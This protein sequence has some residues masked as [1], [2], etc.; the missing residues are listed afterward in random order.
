VTLGIPRLR[1]IVMT[2]TANIATPTMTLT[3]NP[4]VSNAAAAL[5]AKRCSKLMLAEI[6]DHVSVTETIT[7][8][9]K[10]FLIRLD[11]FSA[12]EYQNE[13]SL[14]K[15]K[16]LSVLKNRFLKPLEAAITKALGSKRARANAVAGS[17]EAAPKIG[18]AAGPSEQSRPFPESRLKD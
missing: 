18:E 9:S 11:L 10:D 16:V 14:T 1:E 15:A 13:Y 8:Q 3:L 7:P 17:D 12:N 4:E 6:I 2:A 5:F